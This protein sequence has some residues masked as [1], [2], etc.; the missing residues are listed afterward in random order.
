MT[1]RHAETWSV[2]FLS[3]SNRLNTSATS[4]LQIV[5]G[6]QKSS[7]AM[8]AM[9]S[10]LEENIALFTAAQEIIQDDSSVGNA[11]KT[12]SMRIR[13]KVHC[14]HIAKAICYV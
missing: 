5:N 13:G 3:E 1:N 8:A 7:A 4:N 12:V 11:L 14:L 10:T 6:L 9:D 2:G